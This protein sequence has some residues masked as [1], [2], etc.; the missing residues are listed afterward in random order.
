ENRAEAPDEDAQTSQK[1]HPAPEPR[2][3]DAG[4]SP[5]DEVPLPGEYLTA[6]KP[7]AAP[8]SNGHIT[9]ETKEG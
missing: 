4:S 9:K 2:Q 7:Y 1:A 5:D 6:L 8:P 3:G